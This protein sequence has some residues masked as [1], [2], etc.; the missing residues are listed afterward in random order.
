[1]YYDYDIRLVMDETILNIVE[2]HKHLGIVLASN[3]K[4]SSHI[5]TKFSPLQSRYLF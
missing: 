3:K 2:T 4:W 1:M 5:D